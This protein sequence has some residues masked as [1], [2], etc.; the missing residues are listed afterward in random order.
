MTDVFLIQL[1]G[2]CSTIPSVFKIS[3]KRPGSP[4]G[5]SLVDCPRCRC[6]WY[7]KADQFEN[8]CS[9]DVM[10]YGCSSTGAA[11][12]P[13]DWEIHLVQLGKSQQVWI[14]T[15]PQQASVTI[16]WKTTS[17]M[18]SKVR[19]ITD[20]RIHAVCFQYCL[21]HITKALLKTCS[22]CNMISDCVVCSNLTCKY[23]LCAGDTTSSCLTQLEGE[24]AWI[25]PK[26]ALEIRP[27][28]P[29]RG[30]FYHLLL[31]MNPLVISRNS[32]SIA[33]Y[34]IL[35]RLC[36]LVRHLSWIC[37]MNLP[38]YRQRLNIC[39]KGRVFLPISHYFHCYHCFQRF[40]ADIKMVKY[41]AQDSNVTSSWVRR[42]R[43]AERISVL[44]ILQGNSVFEN[45]EERCSFVG[46]PKWHNMEPY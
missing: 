23:A 4:W 36:P 12:R 35:N 10:C 18:L 3:V 13:K 34:G 33:I 38:L 9:I 14:G 21:L 39:Q 32:Q 7:F 20:T 45:W 11:D 26:H 5:L 2:Q 15:I 17:G 25:C 19:T 43:N 30:Q 29:V 8:G 41:P 42:T 31:M 16:A 22:F 6:N 44:V 37:R 24:A 40:D 46:L 1:R 28:S 27:M